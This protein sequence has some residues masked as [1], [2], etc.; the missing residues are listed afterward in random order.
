[1][2]YR[3]DALKYF[4]GFYP[5]CAQRREGGR[6][7]QRPGELLLPLQ[8][9]PHKTLLIPQRGLPLYHFKMFVEAGKVVKTTF[10][11]DLFYSQF[12]VYQQFAGMAYPY[13]AYKLR[14]GF[15]AS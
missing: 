7:K 8:T 2:H 9:I 4:D 5:V 15:A 12:I 3:A 10:V 6:A 13:F 11:A 14:V 1:M